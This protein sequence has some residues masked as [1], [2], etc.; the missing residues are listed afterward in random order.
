M[1]ISETLFAAVEDV[2]NHLAAESVLATAGR[3][4]GLVPAYSLVT[5]LVELCEPEPSLGK[6]VKALA[7]VRTDLERRLDAAQPFDAAS[8][9]DI[10]R[11]TEFLH[12]GLTAAR[13]GRTVAPP[14]EPALARQGAAAACEDEILSLDLSENRDLLKD[15]Y[16]EAVEHL[17]HIEASL[18]ALDQQP[19][20]PEAL[21]SIFRSFHTIKG[22][23]GFLGLGPMHRLAH[24]VE[25]LLD[26][27][28]MRTLRLDS[29]IITEVLH[30]RDALQQLTQ[31][32]GAALETGCLPDQ[33]VPIGRLIATLHGLSEGE[34]AGAGPDAETDPAAAHQAG[35]EAGLTSSPA[36]GSPQAVQAGPTVRVTTEKLDSLMDV[37]GELVVVQ[38]Q[39]AETARSLAGTVP[40]LARTVALASRITKELQNT[41]MSLR[42]IPIKPTF[43]KMERLARDLAGEFGKRVSFVTSGEDT[44]LD[45]TM[46]E[47][48]G[49]PLVH[50][51][52]NALDHGL[53]S[54][55]DRIASGKPE[56][57]SVNLRAYY[58]G[59]NVIVELEDDGRGLMPEKILAKARSLNLVP[60]NADLTKEEIFALIF[61][62]GFSTA[63][64]IT[65]VSGRG[66]GMDVVRRNVE[67][68]LR[69]KI[70]I[71]SEAG[72][73]SL[74]SIKL[75]LTLAIIDGL[76]VQ[77][78]EDRFILPSASVQMALRPTRENVFSLH[79]DREMLDVRGR[80]MPLRRLNRR[81]GIPARAMD[82]WD[83]IVLIIECSGKFCALLVDEMLSKQEVVIKSLGAYMQGLP[84]VSGGAI[85]GDGNIA[86]ILD[87]GSLLQAA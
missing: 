35:A 76:I 19:D 11:L 25:S 74:F 12:A 87:P 83:G 59:N 60:A 54:P 32:V 33:A 15:F 26:K 61:L 67:S 62:P 56:I 57:G 63:E 71:S 42:M 68:K 4:D 9:D 14:G 7:R 82:P 72:R 48:I 64:K 51:V 22:N 86:L 65:A 53:E 2:V 24:E 6:A 70:D 55:G 28:R 30:S 47:Q 77:V 8:L 69:G 41:A 39:L 58:Q 18:L 43:Q 38:S 23:A 78:G 16:G 21:N 79:G 52:R 73:G 75:P 29:R 5:Q 37:V 1:P 44:E 27:A 17:Q 13:Q 66:V 3:D 49:D 20:D 80:M 34:A 84:G 31:Q 45:R 46:V 36:P 40:Q 81:F 50:M 85:L 10:H